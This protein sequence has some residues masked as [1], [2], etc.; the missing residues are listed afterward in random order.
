MF[1]V[2]IPTPDPVSLHRVRQLERALDATLDTIEL[3]AARL[4]A[5]FGPDFLGADLAHLTAAGKLEEC[6]QEVAQIDRFISEGHSSTAVRRFHDELGLT[7][8]EAQLTVQR[9]SRFG[10][11]DK[12]RTIRFGRFIHT[13]GK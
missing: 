10:A 12:L 8:D 13:V 6:Q 1:P 2:A 11:A 7:W 9:W 5:K 3:L 4:E